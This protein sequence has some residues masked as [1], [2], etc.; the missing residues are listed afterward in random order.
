MCRFSLLLTV[1][2]L[3]V[4][5]PCAKAA[6]QDLKGYSRQP[7]KQLLADANI[8]LLLFRGRIRRDVTMLRVAASVTN[9]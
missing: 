2:W 9:G 7:A 4:A 8:F 5:D 1:S 3:Q 6:R